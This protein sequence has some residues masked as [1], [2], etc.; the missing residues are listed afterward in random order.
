MVIIP[1]VSVQLCLYFIAN[2]IIASRNRIWNEREVRVGNI[3]IPYFSMCH[4]KKY[5]C[6]MTTQQLQNSHWGNCLGHWLRFG[7]IPNECQNANAISSRQIR[8]RQ[9][10]LLFVF[11]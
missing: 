6:F 11:S 9:H 8:K 10:H 1:T 4:R 3:I 5:M 2:I 7:N